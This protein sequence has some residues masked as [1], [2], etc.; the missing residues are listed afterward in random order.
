[1]QSLQDSTNAFVLNGF[2]L[3][4]YKAIPISMAVSG[5]P[6]VLFS[7]PLSY[8][9]GHLL[10]YRVSLMVGFMCMYLYGLYGVIVYTVPE[11]AHL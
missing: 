9:L 3:N 8:C 7:F 6:Y 10:G 1:M 5:M 11:T 4:S 2:G